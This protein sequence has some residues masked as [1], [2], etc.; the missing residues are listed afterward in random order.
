MS[1]DQLWDCSCSPPPIDILWGES[2][3]CCLPLNFTFSSAC[4]TYLL[5]CCHLSGCHSSLLSSLQALLVSPCPQRRIRPLWC[6][7]SLF[8][9]IMWYNMIDFMWCHVCH[10]VSCGVVSCDVMLCHVMWCMRCY[11]K[12]CHK[13]MM[14]VMQCYV[15][16]CHVV[17]MWCDVMW[18]DVMWCGVI[19]CDVMWSDVM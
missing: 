2:F 14:C 19:K 8:C 3:I 7:Y 11:V 5:P 13:M 12:R 6:P 4:L 1:F 17:W 10:V 18:C 9:D 15:L 16:W